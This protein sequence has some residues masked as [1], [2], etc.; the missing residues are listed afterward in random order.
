MAIHHY[1]NVP[2]QQFKIVSVRMSQRVSTQLPLVFIVLACLAV[3]D[4]VVTV[5][6]TRSAVAAN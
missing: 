1:Y 6:V 5:T 2:K 3:L 4:F